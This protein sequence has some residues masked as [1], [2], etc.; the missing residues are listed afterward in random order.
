MNRL[1]EKEDVHTSITA[2]KA[3]L[4]TPGYFG[5]TLP[6]LHIAIAQ[7][8]VKNLSSVDQTKVYCFKNNNGHW[9][10]LFLPENKVRKPVYRPFKSIDEL[11]D[12]FYPP[13]DN[14]YNSIEKA[15]ILLGK[16]LVLRKLENDQTKA[17]VIQDIEFNNTNGNI[18]LNNLSLDYI[19]HVYNIEKDSQWVTFGV[20]E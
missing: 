16:K 4:K 7:H 9:N 20:E 10:A 11:F 6:D 18:Y 2:D 1:F 13:K 5:N 3:T 14:V 15:E 17:M 8:D 19:F 12:F